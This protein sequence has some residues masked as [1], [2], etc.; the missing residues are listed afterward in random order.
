M[1]P[2]LP[3]VPARLPQ[4]HHTVL[5]P[6]YKPLLRPDTEQA[7]PHTLSYQPHTASVRLPALL[8]S[9]P[10]APAH[11]PASRWS[12]YKWYRIYFVYFSVSFFPDSVY[13]IHH[14]T[15]RVHLPASAHSLQP[16]FCRLPAPSLHPGSFSPRLPDPASPSPASALHHRSHSLHHRSHP[17]LRTVRSQPPLHHLPALF[18]H[19][20][21][22]HSPHPVFPDNESHSALRKYLPVSAVLLLSAYHRH[23]YKPSAY[24]LLLL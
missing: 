22:F 7:V 3:S 19:P 21:A 4:P 12:P 8:F 17:R 6:L 13:S 20:P 15:A 11:Y 24:L 1:L 9:D 18:W 2:V 10:A 5:F 23:P 14:L 16:V